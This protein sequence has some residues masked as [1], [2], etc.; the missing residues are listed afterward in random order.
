MTS[1]VPTCRDCNRPRKPD[2][3]FCECGAFYDYTVTTVEQRSDGEPKGKAVA[4]TTVE[5]FEWQPAQYERTFEPTATPPVSK[6]VVR[7]RNC[8]ELNPRDIRHLLALQEAF[9][10]GRRGE[11]PWSLRRFLRLE[12]AAACRR[13]GHRTTRG[14]G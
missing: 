5:E 4:A 10:R 9:G 3:L 2:E 13:A 1:V 12:A 11:P 6:R 14:R 8:D 7:C